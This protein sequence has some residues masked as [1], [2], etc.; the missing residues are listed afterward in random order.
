ML[1]VSEAIISLKLVKMALLNTS[2]K[3]MRTPFAAISGLCAA[4]GVVC[5]FREKSRVKLSSTSMFTRSAQSAMPRMTRS[6][7][8]GH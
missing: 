1:S 5:A 4:A 8:A 3:C 2:S 6:V 7:C